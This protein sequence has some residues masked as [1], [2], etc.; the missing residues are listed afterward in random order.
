MNGSNGS[1]QNTKGDIYIQ[2]KE[3]A[4]KILAISN[5]VLSHKKS[6]RE[7]CMQMLQAFNKTPIFSFFTKDTRIEEFQK[8]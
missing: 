7:I 3:F 5:L 2:T 8:A 1:H 6:I 4:S